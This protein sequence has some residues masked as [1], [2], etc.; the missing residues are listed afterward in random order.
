[1]N[2]KKRQRTGLQKTAAQVFL[3]EENEST[4]KDDQVFDW[5]K[6]A[7][8]KK[9]MP[10]SK[11]VKA[12]R[13]VQEGMD[14][15][16]KG[17][18]WEAIT[19]WD[20]SLETVPNQAKIY[21]MKAQVLMEL[22]EIFPAV[23]CALKAVSLDPQWAIAYQTLGRTQLDVG[24]IENALKNFQRAFHIDPLL[25]EIYREDICWCVE[26]RRRK[27]ELEEEQRKLDL[28]KLWKVAEEA[29]AKAEDEDEEI[30]MEQDSF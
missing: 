1:M 5:V 24:D 12:K 30:H 19:R 13:L 3:S 7:K 17:R 26:L 11:D 18:F 6:Q 28:D 25:P 10:E 22:N 4:D 23:D 21:E 9:A 8:A 29:R 2:W 16:E 20:E 27:K 15:A 14:L